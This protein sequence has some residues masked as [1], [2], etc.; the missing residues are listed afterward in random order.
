MSLENELKSINPECFV[1]DFESL[2]E[3]MDRDEEIGDVTD[4]FIRD[5]PFAL[6][7]FKAISRAGQEEYP[8]DEAS[9]EAFEAGALA[10]LLALKSYSDSQKL[11]EMLQ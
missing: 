9:G 1:A 6:D 8:D 10:V 3:R 11:G 4:A 7:F 2:C 5:Y